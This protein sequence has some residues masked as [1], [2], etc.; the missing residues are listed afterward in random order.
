MQGVQRIIYLG[1]PLLT[2]DDWRI[3]RKKGRDRLVVSA[4]DKLENQKA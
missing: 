1:A 2:R 3:E 4:L